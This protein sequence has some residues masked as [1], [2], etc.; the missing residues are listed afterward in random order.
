[1]ATAHFQAIMAASY[2]PTGGGVGDMGSHK[3][4]R[5]QFGKTINQIS[6]LAEMD[7]K[8]G[9]LDK[10]TGGTPIASS[11]ANSPNGA[12]AAF[13]KNNS[14]YFVSGGLAGEW[15][16]YVFASATKIDSV[17]FTGASVSPDRNPRG[18]MLFSSDD[19]I[20]WTLQTDWFD[21]AGA[22]TAGQYRQWSVSKTN[23]LR[24]D[25]A[26]HRYWR[27]RPLGVSGNTAYVGL[28]E[29][30]FC[31]DAE[32]DLTTGGT[33]IGST[34]GGSNP[35]SNAFDKSASSEWRSAALTEEMWLGYDFGSPVL[36]QKVKIT[37]VTSSAAH[38]KDF[39]IEFSDDG[40]NWIP[41]T[42]ILDA[43]YGSA[44]EST[45]VLRRL[46]PIFFVSKLSRYI[47]AY[48]NSISVS[49]ISRYIIYKP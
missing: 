35:I 9:G 6:R 15:L 20:S 2:K 7:M 22:L 45:Y 23:Y 40:T 29:L 26:A 49:K 33:G 12:A 13:D 44:A 4:W 34:P 39:V 47:V 38:I 18:M 25:D 28:R 24:N 30:K 21:S 5:V 48:R 46:N 31:D 10:T 17:G 43:V 42:V 32:T 19:G 16:G 36:V 37:T 41:T 3:Y 14:T 1:M 8:I 27:I 11:Q